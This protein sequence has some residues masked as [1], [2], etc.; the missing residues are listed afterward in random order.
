[1]TTLEPV[2]A[3]FRAIAETIVPEAAALDAEQWREVEAIVERAL[4]SRGPRVQRQIRFL[5]RALDAM[6]RLR[7]GR[8]FMEL[9]PEHRVRILAAV[10]SAPALLLRRGFWGLRTLSYMGY[11]A[12]PSAARAL[13]Y[14]ASPRGWLERREPASSPAGGSMP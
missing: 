3:E 11:Y 2:R 1:M 13:G 14:R 4:R 7:Y 5:I 8:R 6:P 9:D 10:E 12:R